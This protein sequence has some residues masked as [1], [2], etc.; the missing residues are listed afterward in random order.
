M[1][2]VKKDNDFVICFNKIKKMKIKTFALIILMVCFYQFVEAQGLK[3]G[4]KAGTDV[5]KIT[6]NTFDDGFN[7]GYHA[8]AFAEVKLNSHIGLQPEVYFSQVN[9]KKGSSVNSIYPEF[10]SLKDIQLSYLNIPLLLN[11]RPSS[12][13]AFQIGPQYGILMDQN[14]NILANGKEAIKRGDFSM[15]GGAQFNFLKF[16]LYG[17]YL[18]GLNELNDID[19]REKWKSQ[20]IHVGI[21]YRFL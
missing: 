17:R 2:F 13:F 8:G 20:T 19:N 4:I 15:V 5:H 14:A 3:L 7:F 18:V 16:V 9:L 11:L 1:I 21:G 6:G 10:N 12:K